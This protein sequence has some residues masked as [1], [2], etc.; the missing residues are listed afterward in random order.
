M[1]QNDARHWSGRFAEPMADR[2][3]DYNASIGNDH[4][5][6]LHDV[7]G[8]LAHSR[9]LV[10][11]GILS[12][13]DGQRIERG[14]QAIRAE[15]EQG[16]F[17]W[18][19]EH[20][21]VHFNI[22]RRLTQDIGEAGKRLHTARSRNDQVATDL[23]LYTRDAI[24]G[25]VGQIDELQQSLVEQAQRHR[26]TVMPGC[27]H[28][29]PAQ[30]VTFGHHLM[31]Y[32]EMFER[33]RTRLIDCRVRVDVLP[34]GSAA[35]A[36]TTFPIDRAQVAQELGFAAISRN[37]IDAVS[38][39]DFALEFAFAC[40]LAMV[41]LSRLSEEIVLWMSQGMRFID[42]PDR[43][44]T[45]SSIMPQKK[46]PDIA[47][48]AR[49]KSARA[50][51]H[52]MGLLALMKG[53]PLAYNKDN[54]E[55]QSALF[56]SHETLSSTLA[57]FAEL[58]AGLTAQVQRMSDAA[59][60]GHA[61][62]TDLADHLVRLG[63]PFRGAHETV[64]AAVSD[65]VAAGVELG[66]LSFIQVRAVVAR[67]AGADIARRLDEASLRDVLSV[68]GS[69]AARH[70]TGGTAPEAVSREVARMQAALAQ[71]RSQKLCMPTGSTP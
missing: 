3:R 29:Q 30:P 36:G 27:T 66:A 1:T 53:Q 2:L 54:Q 45:G 12:A 51:G 31:A 18:S 7:R 19:V 47:E 17:A 24:D 20:E 43:F 21:D 71:R 39:R 35:L 55:C 25:L 4:R 64:S 41:H 15:I 61:T 60:A 48:L 52:L 33:D 62:A 67:V 50:I 63:V 56:E 68:Q 70:H 69:V 44:C 46:N 57:V 13:E 58:M 11:Q 59:G 34:L 28:L 6:A 23:R 65:A 14:L 8:S 22:E 16:A 10:R 26:A 37:S 9:M 38:D 5:L 40:S 49:G 42:L 32:V